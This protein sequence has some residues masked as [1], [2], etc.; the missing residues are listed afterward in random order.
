MTPEPA[1]STPDGPASSAAGDAAW[2]R[3]PLYDAHEALG[4]KLVPF[5]GWLMPLAYSDGTL[6]EHRACRTSA[7]MFDVSHLGTV[8][9]Q[10]ADAFAALQS[11][12]TNDLRK[13]EPGRA[14]Y[15]HLLDAE[16]GSVLDDIIVWWLDDDVFDVMPNASNTARVRAVLHGTDTTE[17]RAVIAVQG[18]QARQ[19]LAGIAPEAAAVG[20]F[21]VT[22]FTWHG[23]TCTAAGT[24][25]TGEDGVE[26]AIAADHALDVLAGVA[27]CAHHPGRVG[28][29]RHLAPRGRPA[30]ARP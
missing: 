16:D 3:S 27:R 13:I 28:S 20:R 30:V 14:Q 2:R 24:G 29:A 7:V 1:A 6:A 17:G 5:G 12:L 21:R 18:P 4:A 10:G 11:E 22:P 23:V 8:R 19:M 26:C 9:V 25:Y 15:T